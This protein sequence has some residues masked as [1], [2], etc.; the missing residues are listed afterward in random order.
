[1][2]LAFILIPVLY[3]LHFLLKFV[4]CK[5]GSYID[6]KK[7]GLSKL[8]F[9]GY[10]ITTVMEGYS[11]LCMCCFINLISFINLENDVNANKLST[12]LTYFFLVLLAAFP[13]I[14][15]FILLK[16]WSKLE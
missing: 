12:L 15:S 8:I 4:W 14:V 6:R 3:I 7:E 10:P 9:W 5:K 13:G 1:M 2:I 16:N 11:V